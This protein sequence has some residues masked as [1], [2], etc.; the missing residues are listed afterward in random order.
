MSTQ[1]EYNPHG[2]PFPGGTKATQF[3][4]NCWAQGF[5]PEEVPN[6][7]E[8]QGLKITLRMATVAYEAFDI[9][10]DLY[11]DYEGTKMQEEADFSVLDDG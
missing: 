4:A 3:L 11:Y 10:I 2:S 1:D 9:D 5:Q 6:L 7:A 8:E